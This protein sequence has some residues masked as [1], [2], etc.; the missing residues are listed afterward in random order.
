MQ[1]ADRRLK[2]NDRQGQPAVP[3]VSLSR[4]AL[5]LVVLLG[6]VWAV[7]VAGQAAATLA[8]STPQINAFPELSVEFKLTDSTGH[9]IRELD[10]SQ[11]TVIENEKELPV[12]SL[13][14]AY[15]GIYFSLVINGGREMDL[16]DAS[17]IS[18]YRKMTDALQSWAAGRHFSGEDSWSLMTNE[19]LVIEDASNAVAWMTGLDS[20]QPNLRQLEPDLISLQEAIQMLE[21][22][23]PVFGVDKAILYLTPPPTPDQISGVNTLAEQAR[24]AGIQVNV[25]MVGEAYYLTNDQ[26]G[27]LIEMA[28]STGGEFFHYTGVETLP[29]LTGTLGDL[30]YA[31]RLTYESELRATGSYPLMVR[32]ILGDMEITGESLPFYVAVQPPNPMLLAPPVSISREALIGEGTEDV[33]YSPSQVDLQILIEYPDGHPRDLVASRLL[34]D[35]S[36]TDVNV[37]APFDVFSWDISE[38]TE[39]GEHTIQVEVEDSLGLSAATLLTPIRIEIIEPGFAGRVSLQQIGLL[40]SGV[41]AGAGLVLLGVWVFRK[42]WSVNQPRWQNRRQAAGSMKANSASEEADRVEKRYAVLVPLESFNEPGDE[43]LLVVQKTQVL[44]GS[45]PQQA[46]LVISSPDVEA[47]QAELTLDAEG[48]WLRHLGSMAQTT[49]LNY[50]PVG[51]ERVQVRP[52]DLLHFGESGFRFTMEDDE[53]ENKVSISRYEP[54]S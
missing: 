5:T 36:V 24:L 33:T 47:I 15:R 3:G 54:F 12:T 13:S 26:G 40:V 20:Y 7:P 49:W 50:R 1:R 53:P 10:V 29:D 37:A 34:V 41:V 8:V 42:F 44:I 22:A 19:G 11:L 31:A 48:F 51:A 38:L 45:D 43:N 6:V 25:W 30:G 39:T 18:R 27:S 32:A 46:D 52:G 9:P 28:A 16:R 14:E 4:T 35:G 17:G 2:Q 23:A 21:Q